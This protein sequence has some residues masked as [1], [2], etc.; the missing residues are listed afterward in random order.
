MTIS[1]GE[2]REGEISLAIEIPPNFAANVMRGRQAEVAAWIDGAMPT[3]AETVKGYVQGVHANWLTQKAR[4]LYG[5]AATAGNFNLE[6]R[7][8][9]NP[10]VQS[11]VA[12]VPA[13]IPLL[14]LMIPAMLAVL[15][16]VREKELGLDHQ[17]LRNASH[18]IRVP[19]GQS[20]CPISGW[21]S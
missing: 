16:V 1:T 10:D 3:R 14:L 19:A 11:L 9:Y 8:R 17:F 7:Y 4:A 12:M 6:I 13:V 18:Q 2:V 5:D 15:S 21:H 20:N